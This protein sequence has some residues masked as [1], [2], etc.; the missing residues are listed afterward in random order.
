MPR[1]RTKPHTTHP[2]RNPHPTRRPQ[3]RLPARPLTTHPQTRRPPIARP[4]IARPRTNSRQGCCD[5]TRN[6]CSC[7]HASSAHA[8]A[9]R[10]STRRWRS[11]K[12]A[13]CPEMCTT[14]QASGASGTGSRP[15]RT[16]PEL[17]E[18][19]GRLPRCGPSHG[20]HPSGVLEGARPPHPTAAYL[21]YV[22]SS[23]MSTGSRP[24]PRS[25]SVRAVSSSRRH[26]VTVGQPAQ[27][28]AAFPLSHAT[29]HAE[30]DA[31][32]QR[33][34]QALGPHRASGAHRL[35]PVLRCSLNEQFIW[36]GSA[37]GRLRTPV[38]YPAHTG[39][40]LSRIEAPPRRQ[41]HIHRR[42]LRTLRKVGTAQHPLRAQS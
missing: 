30:L 11:P 8:T 34:G 25:Y 32:V 27:K 4:P 29:P 42:Q 16:R 2:Q 39:A 21:S 15:V 17:R 1:R 7:W 24:A 12:S 38:G 9:S 26:E 13:P 20:S 40:V 3:A 19:F 10:R 36:I 31:V 5:C 22:S 28:C 14:W 41:R 37:A 35:R 33:V 6:A 18:P 23:S